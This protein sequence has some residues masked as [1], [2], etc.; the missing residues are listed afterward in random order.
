M[1]NNPQDRD[2][3]V[4]KR[5][6]HI[7]ASRVGIVT[8][9]KRDGKP[10]AGYEDYLME[11]VV[12]RLTEKAAEHFVSEAMQW[13]VDQEEAAAQ[14]YA[15]E[16]GREVAYS[17][18]V[19]STTIP[20]SGA[21]PDRLVGD[22][23]LLEIKCPTTRTHV[24]FL[25]TGEIAEDYQ[26]QMIWQMACTGRH[27]CDFMSYDPRLPIHLQSKIKRFHMDAEMLQAAEIA[28]RDALAWI[29]AKE[30]ALRA[31]EPVAQAA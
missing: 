20:M 1:A 9:R 28:V 23:G 2:S 27:W 31:L 7:T 19:P 6:G 11:V 25:L 15:F 10:Y 5:R 3:W 14:H 17:D 22:D 30:S 26:W 13:G 21:S 16:T 18:F 4:A 24:E 12:E 8:R 29:D